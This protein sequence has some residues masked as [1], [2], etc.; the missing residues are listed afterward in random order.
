MTNSNPRKFEEKAYKFCFMI[1]TKNNM[2][3][4]KE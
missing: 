4:K 1:L 3:K 2:Q